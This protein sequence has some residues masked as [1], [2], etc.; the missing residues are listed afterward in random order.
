[1]VADLGEYQP[2]FLGLGFAPFLVLAHL[3]FNLI[4][5]PLNYLTVPLQLCYDKFLP[6]GIQNI[7]SPYS[8]LCRMIIRSGVNPLGDITF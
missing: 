4:C 3:T 8:Y 1:M 6:V 5:V 7:F 2:C